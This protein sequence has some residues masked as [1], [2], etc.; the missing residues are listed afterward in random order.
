MPHTNN[1]KKASEKKAQPRGI[2]KPP[3]PNEKG[4]RTE[5]LPRNKNW[6]AKVVTWCDRGENENGMQ[7]IGELAEKGVTAERLLE[8]KKE[9]EAMGTKCDYYDLTELLDEAE[10]K[11][12]GVKEL[13]PAAVLV[14][15]GGISELLGE[16]DA[17]MKVED[18][19]E[20]CKDD[21]HALMYGD[22]RL[23]SARWNWCFGEF[24][25]DPDYKNGRGSVYD[26]REKQFEYLNHLREQ[27]T[28]LV[29]YPLGPDKMLLCGE[30][31]HYYDCTFT[32]IGWHGDKERRIV[33]GSRHGP[34]TVDMPVKWCWLK[35]E[36]VRQPSG[37]YLQETT[38]YGKEQWVYVGRDDLYIMSEHAVGRN[39][40]DLGVPAL[41]HSSGSGLKNEY[42]MLKRPVRR[43]KKPER[44][45][46]K[47]ETHGIMFPYRG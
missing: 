20:R 3:K 14:L 21:K 37:K 23:K 44:L 16:N 5:P 11:R 42:S 25:Q 18:E 24:Q 26:I 19:L 39:W 12:M 13:P 40:K 41:V 22:V 27:A 8:I 4:P 7:M 34:G 2:S 28:K 32:G 9:Q 38:Y 46:R 31:N 35:K 1:K 29:D 15:R 6:W 17:W 30:V 43:G 47:G 45:L 10:L 33:V 36:N